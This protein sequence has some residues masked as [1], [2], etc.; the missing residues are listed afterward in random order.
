MILIILIISLFAIKDFFAPGF[1]PIHDDTQVQRVFEMAKS[2]KD[3]LFPVRWVSDLGYGYGYPI[4]N[5]YAPLPYYIAGFLTLLGFDVLFS[6]KIMM[7]IGI[8]IAGVF[9]YLLGREFWGKIGGFISSLFYLYAPYHA[10]QIFVRGDVGEFWAYGFIPL[11]FFGFYKVFKER[12]WRWIILG[13]TSYAALILSHNLTAM[14]VS[15]FLII[16]IALFVYDSYRKNK[17]EKIKYLILTL[18]F[19]LMI[20]SFYWI[21]ALWEM[22][23]TNALS[24]V[25]GGADFRDHFVCLSQLW[26]SMWGFGGSAS[27]CADGLSFRI[28]KAHI[29]LSLLSIFLL[30][31]IFKKDK[32]I[33]LVLILSQVLLFITFFMTL[34]VSKFFWEVIPL[35]SFFQ[36]PW[37]FLILVSFSSSFLAG[38]FI[39][40]FKKSKLLF[41]FPLILL[42]YTTFN[43]FQPQTILPKSSKDY[44][45]DFSLKWITSKTSDEYMPKNFDKPKSLDEVPKSKLVVKMGN[46]EISEII[47]KTNKITAKIL[48]KDEALLH[49]NVAYF[50]AWKILINGKDSSF[51]I[52]KNGLDFKVPKGKSNIDIL[53]EQTP[54]EKGSNLLSIIAIIVMY[55]GIMRRIK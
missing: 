40:F 7:V 49:A 38:F 42:F 15:P 9:M 34:K 55:T 20:P 48:S 44:V 3:G 43:I 2:L 13:A 16:L 32:K 21:P 39:Y 6:T 31:S 47:E 54:V 14:M 27:G 19:G 10:V 4:F 23:F 45:N 51:E 37:R 41:I 29:L 35:M 52:K 11:V 5:F 53:F 12:K 1:F 50:P 46:A 22:R 36:F 33:F 28:G 8:V 25:G 30:P 17:I 26:E 18:L 24:Q